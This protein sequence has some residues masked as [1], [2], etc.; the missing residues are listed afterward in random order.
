M[1]RP[2]HAMEVHLRAV[3][4]LF[5]S[6]DPSPFVARDLDQDAE[7]FIVGWA[8]ELPR[9]GEFRLVIHL[10]Q[11][12][13]DPAVRERVAAAVRNFFTY[14]TRV[15]SR[16]FSQLMREGR[17]SLAIG[18][19]FLGGCLLGARFMSG[20]AA[21][22]PLVEFASES[23]VIGGWVAMWRPMEIFL[24][25]WWPLARKRSIL[26]RLARMQVELRRAAG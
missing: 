5:N 9:T 23:L 3:Q 13:D 25:E 22:H 19:L 16:E 26:A 12:D 24:Y 4:Q 20:I 2:E 10:D 21:D 8:H 1:K 18:L 15:A 7:E 14:R 11:Y 6:L 17:L